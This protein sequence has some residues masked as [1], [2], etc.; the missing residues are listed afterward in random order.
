MKI[1][2][3]T[4]CLSL[5]L[6]IIASSSIVAQ[7]YELREVS[8]EELLKTKSEI[9][10]AAGAEVL[11]LNKKVYYDIGSSFINLVTEVHKRIKF[12]NT[13]PEDLKYA[14]QKIN[15]YVKRDKESVSKIRAYTYNLVDGEI[16][17]T[18]LDRKQI[19]EKELSDRYEQVSFTMPKV[20]KGS[21]IDIYYKIRSPYFYNIDEFKFQFNIPAQ[22]V[23]AKIY[24]PEGF[25]FN[26]IRKGSIKPRFT[27][28]STIDQRMGTKADI[29]KYEV[30]NV[31]PLKE[32]KYVDNIENYRGG[33]LFE[34]VSVKQSYGPN[35][36]Y[37][38]SWEDVA[39]TIASSDDYKNDINRTNIF[40]DDIDA[41][42]K[43]FPSEESEN[44]E[45]EETQEPP[46][47]LA[48]EIF[49]YVKKNLKWNDQKSKFFSNGIRRTYKEKS[50]NS[51]DINLT[52]VAMLRYAG[53][54]SN[55]IVISTRDNLKPFFPTVDRLNYVIAQVNHNDKEYFLDATDKYSEFNI[56]PI[57]AYNWNGVFVDAPNKLYKLISLKTP[58]ASKEVNLVNATISQNGEITGEVKTQKS[59]HSAYLYRKNYASQAK[60]DFLRD[61]ESNLD[62]ILISNYEVENLDLEGPIVEKYSYTYEN[63]GEVVGNKIFFKPFMFFTND[64]NPFK[65]EERN[66]PVDFIY[67][68][69]DKYIVNIKI[70]EGYKVTSVPEPMKLTFGE[71]IGMYQ[72][73]LSNRGKFL[74]LAVD[75]EMNHSI[76]G[77]D[78]YKFLKQFYNQMIKKQQEQIVLTKTE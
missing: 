2:L 72:Y 59:N 49:R 12:Y 45:D 56:L 52:L 29:Y 3:P 53:F 42:I 58:E 64:E 5:V 43:K 8:K 78:N 1:N 26:R 68:F 15:L 17:E 39:S 6:F 47:E 13:R 16:E 44:S 61:K 14:T 76:I 54:S 51:A 34:L 65:L 70:P 73:L 67:P 24:T 27:L 38:K 10:T 4:Y 74:R 69:S 77:S 46:L 30:N 20:K 40:E 36:N 41:I 60:E 63:A 11:Y 9:D 50:G 62:N 18:K 71:N 33:V 57:R 37:A 55:P 22:K 7:E 28:E 66:F 48:K 23:V 31:P 32:E 25:I 19:F 35:K 75:F 21:V